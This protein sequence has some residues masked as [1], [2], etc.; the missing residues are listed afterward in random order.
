LRASLVLLLLA[1]LV[2]SLIFDYWERR[3]EVSRHVTGDWK[4][5]QE[6]DDGGTLLDE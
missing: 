1:L 6:D 2:L 5:M 3:R 4:E